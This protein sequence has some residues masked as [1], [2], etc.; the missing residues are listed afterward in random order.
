[1]PICAVIEIDTNKVINAIVAEVTDIPPPG[2]FLMEIP[3]N[4]YWDR[5]SEQLLDVLPP[6]TE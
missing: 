6:E 4:K 2:C 1:M 3:A 5:D